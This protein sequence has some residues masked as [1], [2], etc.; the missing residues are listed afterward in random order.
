MRRQSGGT[1][2]DQ[3]CSQHRSHDN[4]RATLRHA[5]ITTTAWSAPT[6]RR[7]DARHRAQC[8]AC[9]KSH[10][11]PQERMSRMRVFK[12]TVPVWPWK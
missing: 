10:L 11:R 1:G 9:R 7:F 2:D 4:S 5:Q 3:G 6:L 8:L 12:M